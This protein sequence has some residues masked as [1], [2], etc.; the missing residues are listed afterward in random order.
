[1]YPN[2]FGDDF[3]NRLGG[4]HFLMSFV[5]AIGSLMSNRG[6]EDIMKAAFDGVAKMLT[7]KKHPQNTRAL[8]LVVEEIL[9]DTLYLVDSYHELLDKLFKMAEASRT[10]KHWVNNLILPV[11]HI[12]IFVR[13]EREGDWPLHLC[14]VDKMIPYF[15]AS[16]HI[17][18]ARYGLVYLISLQKLKG[19]ILERFMEGDHLQRHKQGIFNGMWTDVHRNDI[20]AL[21][22]WATWSH[23]LNHEPICC[24]LLGS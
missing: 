14:D 7:G 10:S 4:M 11:F 21:W 22:T 13:A 8:R 1:V 23:W 12:M 6:L 17:H 3:I 19:D 24:R 9:H 15:F 5:G 16:A 20:N 2:L 18:Y